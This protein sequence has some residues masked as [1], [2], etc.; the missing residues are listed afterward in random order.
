VVAT[1]DFEPAD[2]LEGF[3]TV[4]PTRGFFVSSS[5]RDNFRPADLRWDVLAAR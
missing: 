4:S 5:E 1:Q 2:E 3:H